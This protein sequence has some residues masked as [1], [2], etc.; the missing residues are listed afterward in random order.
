MEEK[1]LF[2]LKRDE[3]LSAAFIG[4]LLAANVVAVKLIGT[5]FVQSA[6]VLAYPITFMITD[7]I[8]D[9]FGK[10]RAKRLVWMG[11]FAQLLFLVVVVAARFVPFPPFWENQKAFEIILGGVPRIVLA[12]LLAY[13]VAQLHD[14]WAFHLWKRITNG[15]HL[16]IRNNA[17]TMISQLL[18]SCVFVLVAFSFSLPWAVVLQMIVVQYVT[19]VII[20]AADTPFVYAAVAWLKRGQRK[21]IV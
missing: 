21:G 1:K 2:L 18:D 11:F 4:S 15:K 7:A 17:S 12:S 5:R 6:G 13:L 8:G 20:A 3:F 14:V 16:W 19:K 10:D 9:V